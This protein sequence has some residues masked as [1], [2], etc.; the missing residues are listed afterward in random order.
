[1]WTK[2]FY[3]NH[4]LCIL[5]TYNCIFYPNWHLLL[6]A[7]LIISGIKFFVLQLFYHTYYWKFKRGINLENTNLENTNQR[8]QKLGTFA[9]EYSFCNFQSLQLAILFPKITGGYFIVLLV[10]SQM[11]PIWSTIYNSNVTS[12]LWGSPTRRSPSVNFGY[13]VQKRIIFGTL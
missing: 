5:A 13:H 4:S 3:L 6:K 2:V 9:I 11:C 8:T 7:N 10:A 1:M 12:L